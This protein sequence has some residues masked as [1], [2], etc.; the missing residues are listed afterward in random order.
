[1]TVAEDTLSY[2][3][4]IRQLGA[5]RADEVACTHAAPDGSEQT[6]TWGWLDRRSSELARWLS[7]RGVGHG[8]RV[9]IGLRNS[10]HFVLTAFACWKLAA[11]PVP[12]RWDIPDWELARVLAVIEPAAHLSESDIAAIDATEGLEVGDVDDVAGADTASPHMH[13]ICSSGST[14]N[15]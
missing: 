11:V 10:P 13:G 2:A 14:G 12:V 9:A 6:S 5:T 8:D 15:S 1:M 7:D 3:Q 4:R